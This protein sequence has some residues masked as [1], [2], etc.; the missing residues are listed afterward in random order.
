VWVNPDIGALG[1]TPHRSPWRSSA[2]GTMGTTTVEA[3][4]LDQSKIAGIGN[5]L[6]DE[7]LWQARMS[8]WHGPAAYPRRRSIASTA[9]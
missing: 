4:L 1:R 2:L 9:R 5:L 6:A 7:I 3:R 8:P